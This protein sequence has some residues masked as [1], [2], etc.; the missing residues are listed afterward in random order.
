VKRVSPCLT[1]S[2]ARREYDRLGSGTRLLLE[3]KRALRHTMMARRQEVSP[4]ERARASAAVNVRLKAL[5]ELGLACA[6]AGIV[7]GFVALAPRG[8][9]DPEAAL[10][11]AA[12]DGA[13]VVLPRVSVEAPRLRFH[14]TK[15]GGD[16][17]EM[18]PGPYG[19]L[20]P[21]AT[22][23]EVDAADIDVMIL[24]GLAFDRRGNRLGYG[25]GYYDEAAGKLRA[26]GRG[27]LV[28]V[29]YD[30]QLVERCPAGE[31]D[32]GVDCVV[33]DRQVVRCAPLPSSDGGRA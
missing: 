8:E 24:P 14:L 16:R 21:A 26:A 20:E 30:F 32:V 1:T 23:P 19:L 7:A 17:G 22:A 4:E 27:F 31:A 2:N 13:R 5:P 12:A 3:E 10:R 25:G 15:S 18:T 33:T 29:A 9:I 6:S 28:G 11:E